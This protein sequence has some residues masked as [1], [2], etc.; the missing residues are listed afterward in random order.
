MER[1]NDKQREQTQLLLQGDDKQRAEQLRRDQEQILQSQGTL[2]PLDSEEI[3]RSSSQAVAAAYGGI[4][5]PQPDVPRKSWG[6]TPVGN[7]EEHDE[8]LDRLWDNTAGEARPRHEQVQLQQQH[9]AWPQQKFVPPEVEAAQQGL[10]Q[11]AQQEQADEHMAAAMQKEPENSTESP[12]KAAGSKT[13][14]QMLAHM[15][16]WPKFHVC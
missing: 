6:D 14:D 1:L 13:T 2:R 16:K 3:A 9:G 4:H 10:L 12:D 8:E 7:E 5:Q 15:G 11:Q